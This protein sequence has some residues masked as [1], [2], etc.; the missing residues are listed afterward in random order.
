MHKLLFHTFI[1]TDLHTDQQRYH[2]NS[3][4]LPIP[5]P[6]FGLPGLPPF[7]GRGEKPPVPSLPPSPRI[8]PRLDY[9]KLVFFY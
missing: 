1:F 4:R 2:L 5:G 7:F 6:P 9:L 8:E 3:D